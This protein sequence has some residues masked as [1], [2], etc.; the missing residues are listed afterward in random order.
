MSDDNE[1]SD[2][3]KDLLGLATANKIGIDDENKERAVIIVRPDDVSRNL[4]EIEEGCMTRNAPL[5]QRDGRLVTRGLTKV[6]TWDDRE[7]ANPTI[8]IMN[9]SSSY[10]LVSRFCVFRKLDKRMGKK[11]E[12]GKSKKGEYKAIE[13]PP[14]LM[15]ALVKRPTLTLPILKA[16]VNHPFFRADTLRLSHRLMGGAPR[17]KAVTVLGKRRVPPATSPR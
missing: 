11:S 17:S 15:E 10:D 6:K 1:P 14:R 4:D 13:P 5:W 8:A 3:L 2:P 12:D 7:V 9:P 16:V